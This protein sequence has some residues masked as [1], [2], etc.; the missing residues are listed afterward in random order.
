MADVFL[1][2]ASEQREVVAQPLAELFVALGLSVWYDQ[3]QIKVGDSLRQKIDEG[4]TACRYGVVILS[5][6]FLHKHHTRRELDGLAQREVAGEK[7]ILPIWYDVTDEEVRSFSPPLADRLAARWSEGVAAVALKI[8][9]V[10]RPDVIEE[11]RKEFKESQ[12]TRLRSGQ[13]IANVISGTHLMYLRNDEPETEAE[14]D[15]I[16]GFIQEV[17]DWGDIWNDLEPG[18]HIRTE[19]HLSARLQE[20]EDAGWTVYGGKDRGRKKLMGVEDDWAWTMFAVV[21]GEAV[22]VSYSDEQFVIVRE[23]KLQV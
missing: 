10:V 19:F 18:E 7:V 9:M 8:L 3:S 21:R 11:V 5:K 22:E 6:A 12:L 4:L 14:V 16:S 13:Q 23:P 20:I 2:Y 17:R 15:L 1:S